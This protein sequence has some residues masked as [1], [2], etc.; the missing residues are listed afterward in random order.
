M[1]AAL[2]VALNAQYTAGHLAESCPQPC[3]LPWE[4]DLVEENAGDLL[5]AS[6]ELPGRFPGQR[7]SAADRIQQ[8]RARALDVLHLLH[9]LG[10]QHRD[11]IGTPGNLRMAIVAKPPEGMPSPDQSRHLGIFREVRDPAR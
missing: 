2:T 1:I 6:E 8:E 4:R 9:V 5:S 3:Q 10:G 7:A 11:H